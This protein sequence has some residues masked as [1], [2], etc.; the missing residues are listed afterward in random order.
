M[1]SVNFA[2][3][4]AE[5]HAFGGWSFHL[6]FTPAYRRKVFTVGEVKELCRKEARRVAEG[7][8]FVI[9]AD[10]FGLDHWHLFV[11]HAKNFS[12][13]E[14]AR[15]LKGA[16]SRRVRLE[17]REAIRPFLWGDHFWSHGYFAETIGRVTSSTIAHYVAHSQRKHWKEDESKGQLTL[18][19]YP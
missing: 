8:G 15:R 18:S 9:Q 13:A 19:H 3:L 6:N 17:L 11:T 7:F 4:E 2:R 1:V 5:N 16:N 10:D 12:A 14:L